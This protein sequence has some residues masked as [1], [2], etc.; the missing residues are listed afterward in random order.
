MGMM[1]QVVS[2]QQQSQAASVGSAPFSAAGV[3]DSDHQQQH[4]VRQLVLQQLALQQALTR[5]QPSAAPF[6][7]SAHT[8][9]ADTSSA[10]PSTSS[11][12]TG[13]NYCSLDSPS[14]PYGSEYT[15][16]LAQQSCVSPRL[17]GAALAECFK[18]PCTDP[19][20]PSCKLEHPPHAK[21]VHPSCG[22]EISLR[23]MLRQPSLSAS[24]PSNGRRLTP[25]S[26][27]PLSCDST[28]SVVKA[29]PL[30]QAYSQHPDAL[31]ELGESCL[32]MCLP[33][34]G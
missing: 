18:P 15:S 4:C 14:A 24:W 29:E 16:A 9:R 26:S 17:D 10:V 27:P 32:A 21:F 28:V 25:S 22:Q 13:N 6:S 31:A 7:P 12:Y 3:Q 30:L 2:Q 20:N 8:W 19:L 11:P 34:C 5:Q 33:T 23:S 1:Q